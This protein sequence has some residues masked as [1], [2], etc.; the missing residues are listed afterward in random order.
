MRPPR[1][2]VVVGNGMAGCRFVQ[3]TLERDADRRLSITVVGDE[4][5][6][7][8]NRMQLS[9]VLAG[10]ASID[11]LTLASEQWYERQGVTLRSGSTVLR[12]DR[13]TKQVQLDEDSAVP[14]DV[15][16]LATGSRAVIPSIPG[17][18]DTENRL[19]PGSVAFRTLADCR[20]ID[21]LAAEARTALVLGAGVL[22]LEAARALA[23]RGLPVTLLQRG[24]RLME[25]QLDA[26]AS[27]ALTRAARC[28][29]VEI[30]SATPRR[31]LDDGRLELDDGSHLRA[32]LMVLCCG[33]RPRVGLARAARLAVASGVVVDDQ[34][35]TSDPDIFAIGECAEHRGRLS[36]LVAPV[37]EQARVAAD[38]VARPDGGSAYHGSPVVTRLKA[39][40]IE[41]ISLG[42][43]FV[44]SHQDDNNVELIHFT[45]SRRGVYQKL[46][47][48]DDRLSGAIL[49]GD[50]R[51]A[52]T[53][54]QL[55][56]RGVRLPADR[57]SLL[58]G[59][60]GSTAMPAGSP[61]TL[62]ARTTVCQCNGVTKGDICDAWADGAR[63]VTEIAS[64]THA[65]T[66]C[67]TCRDAVEGILDWLAAADPDPIVDPDEVAD[68]E[69]GQ[70][71]GVGL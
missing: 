62:P 59:P 7:A 44:E 47:V 68:P 49:L 58:V 66:G 60:R 15:L 21:R 23:G 54:T 64:R 12:I 2:V 19:R 48:R 18:L 10:V 50:T 40:G 34:L 25:R 71:V 69:V 39:D 5:G 6:G 22:G 65:T 30:R 33:V 9:N 63:A 53:L 43:G 4:P 52:G 26:G 8:Y 67:G 20:E 14:F 27:R 55:F 35:R 29:G 46:V 24:A 38:V 31:V 17:L 57:V 51:T 16:V 36:G 45:D 61:T 56:D 42:D 3:E 70:P 41:L 13:V 37:W 32:D 28:L 1:R 11:N